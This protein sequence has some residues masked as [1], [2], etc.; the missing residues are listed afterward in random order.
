MAGQFYFKW[1]RKEKPKEPLEN[2]DI[3][4]E[5]D[6]FDEANLNTL[7]KAWNLLG[8]DCRQLLENFY[9][10]DDQLKEIAKNMKKAHRPC[11]NKNNVALK[12]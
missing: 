5:E 9:Y 6:S 8:K 11:A 4:E 2:I 12:S 10:R 1:I 7:D 3:P